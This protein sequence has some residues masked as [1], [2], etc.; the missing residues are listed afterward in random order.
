MHRRLPRMNSVSLIWRR[1][2]SRSCRF[3]KIDQ[4]RIIDC[5]DGCAVRRLRDF[6][7]IPTAP[8]RSETSVRSDQEARPECLVRPIIATAVI[9]STAIIIRSAAVI[10][11]PVAVTVVIVIALLLGG[12][13]TDGSNRHSH[14][15]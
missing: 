7:D 6:D 10:A 4:S 14:E 2:A 8:A 9:G 13:R 1:F 11:R 3:R 15:G 12:D 5:Y